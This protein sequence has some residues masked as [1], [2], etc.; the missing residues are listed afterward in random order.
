M[1]QQIKRSGQAPKNNLT[2]RT[3]EGTR[4]SRGGEGGTSGGGVGG[5]EGEEGGVEKGIKGGRL[6]GNTGKRGREGT[7]ITNDYCWCHGT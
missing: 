3:K 7:G 5:G 4:K 6:E 1:Q 2:Y